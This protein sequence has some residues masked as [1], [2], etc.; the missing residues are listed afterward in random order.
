[1]QATIEKVTLSEL[2]EMKEEEKPLQGLVVLN[3]DIGGDTI[4]TALRKLA[5]HK[6]LAAPVLLPTGGYAMI[7]MAA[8]GYAI[9]SNINC[10]LEPISTIISISEKIETLDVD[11]SLKD[12]IRVLAG[13]HHRVVISKDGAPY[14]ML[15]Q[16]DVVRF[17]DKHP[18]LLPETARNSLVFNFMTTPPLTVRVDEKV[19]DALK[20]IIQDSFT[21]AAVVDSDGRVQANFSVS[22]LRG[23]P[24]SHHYLGTLMDYSVE[25]YLKET[26]RFAKLPVELYETHTL[27]HAVHELTRHHIHRVHI[28]DKE[29]RPIGVVTTSDVIRCLAYALD[30][31]ESRGTAI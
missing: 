27:G 30:T 17:L 20:R 29:E 5:G 26:K 28:I 6:I 1:M 21:G 14:H 18:V 31:K 19:S 3:G 25:T 15:S 4:E 11:S 22:D 9:A 7:D 10:Y 2:I 8:I 24:T 13:K 16:M 23:I 12:L